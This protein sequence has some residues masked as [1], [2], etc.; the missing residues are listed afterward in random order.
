M[1]GSWISRHQ[2][3]N[4]D[5][6][7][8]RDQAI[9]AHPWQ[10]QGRLRLMRASCWGVLLTCILL[11][12]CES[13]MTVSSGEAAFNAG[14]PLVNEQAAHAPWIATK[15][16]TRINTDDHVKAAVTV[17]RTVWPGHIDEQRPNGVVLVPDEQWA[18][19][20]AAADLIHFPNNGPLLYIKSDRIPEETRIELQRLKPKGSPDNKGVQAIVV[21]KVEQTVVD[22]VKKMGLKVDVIAGD[23]PAAVAAAVDDYYARVSKERPMSVIIAS[24]DDASY[25]LPA[26]NWIAHMPEPVLYVSKQGIPQSTADAL[27]KRRKK[28]VMYVLG[29]ENTIPQEVTDELQVFGRIERISAATPV[30]QAI[31][32]A[33]YKD[34]K[35]GF[36]WGISSPGHNFSFVKQGSEW[37][38]I[39][40]AP[41]AHL[42]K[43][44]PLLYVQGDQV[45]MA[46]Y[47]Y[48]Q[49]IRPHY[50][51]TP[52]E[53]PYNAAWLTGAEM[54]VV[55]RIQSELDA[56]LEIQPKGDTGHGSAHHYG[57]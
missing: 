13:S 15:N 35:T 8:N 46:V 56:L 39:A 14:E 21:G 37:L 52:V 25:A 42:G 55:P 48:V 9:E 30:E 16:M 28:A 2:M 50:E 3:N 49:S 54:S 19:A 41:F 6:K 27:A 11:A 47:D 32:F 43:H 7:I 40:Q 57:S 36:G 20:M 4:R 10:M 31:A 5:D 23:N 24:S 18:V 12:G 17:S 53:G 44:A 34:K 51:H 26:V 38:A 45:P 33:R 1:N 29:S 22:E